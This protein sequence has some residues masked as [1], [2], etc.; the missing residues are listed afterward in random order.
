MGKKIQL[1]KYNLA[2]ISL[3]CLQ[4][5][6]LVVLV[7]AQETSLSNVL[8]LWVI[9]G[10]PINNWHL[11]FKEWQWSKIKNKKNHIYIYIFILCC[12]FEFRCTLKGGFRS[13]IMPKFDWLLL[14]LTSYSI[15]IHDEIERSGFSKYYWSFDALG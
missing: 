2:R 5:D 10:K 14:A 7:L 8:L 15:Q 13:V 3:Y 11:S 9:N 1:K 6:M 12:G 4:T